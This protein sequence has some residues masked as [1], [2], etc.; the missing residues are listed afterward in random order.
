MNDV[1]K[2]F[3]IFFIRMCIFNLNMISF[4]KSSNTKKVQWYKYHSPEILNATK[5]TLQNCFATLCCSNFLKMCFNM[6]IILF[7]KSRNNNK[8]TWY[9]YH[10]L[11]IQPYIIRIVQKYIV[12][13]VQKCCWEHVESF[14][15][16]LS[17]EIRYTFDIIFK[18]FKQHRRKMRQAPFT[19]N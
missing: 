3:L 8:W 5:K 13:I 18:E 11:E 6:S 19:S 1:S 10:L 17:W 7:L 9:K 15:N 4:L 2:G 16:I 14:K 12:R